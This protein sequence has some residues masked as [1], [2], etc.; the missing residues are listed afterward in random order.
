MSLGKVVFFLIRKLSTHGIP[1][2]ASQGKIASTNR[3]KD[4]E[5]SSSHKRF[6]RP[7]YPKESA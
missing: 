4:A 5:I 1:M 6:A 7:A 3:A 2:N